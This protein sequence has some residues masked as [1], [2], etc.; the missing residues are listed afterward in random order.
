MGV[1]WRGYAAL[2]GLIVLGACAVQPGPDRLEGRPT[3]FAALTGW[4]D[5]QPGAA[6]G[7]FQRSCRAI[8]KRADQASMGGDRRFGRVGDWREV[9]DR[10]LALTID[11]L[12]ISAQRRFFEDNFV[13]VALSNGRVREGLF[14]GYYEPLL[15][16]ARRR[17]GA[18]QTPLLRRPDDLV[19]VDLGEFRND[20]KGRRI[21]G[22]VRDGRL[23]PYPSR[24]DIEDGILDGQGLELAWVDDSVDAF[25]LQIQGSG[26]VRLE[27]GTRIRVGYD[28]VNG[29]PYYAIGRALVAR[30]ALSAEAVSLQSIR[31][32]LAANPDQARDVMN[33][34]PSYVFFR[35]ITGEGP[36]GAQG[37]ALTAGRS[38]AVD[39]RYL[40][41][42]VPLW[43]DSEDA[44]RD[45]VAWRRLMVA[46]D[47]G[48]AIRGPVRGDVFYGAG[49]DA[50]ARAG[51]MKRS[52]RYTALVPPA[53]A[54]RFAP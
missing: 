9:C 32:W 2:A 8:V 5:D 52:G 27:D 19:M 18:Y 26:L 21:A 34:N 10:A 49:A 46:Q 42:G 41:L 25:F 20:F 4:S 48:G 35:E 47:T 28:G 3:G 13:P 7:A 14:T 39:R 33:L 17:G 53:V 51:R 43:L 1:R 6:L 36:I 11:T 50:A 31:A 12:D 23:K 37:V 54:A 15:S 45:G 44:L 16:G 24:A 30:G 29:R 40:A 38:L 22:L